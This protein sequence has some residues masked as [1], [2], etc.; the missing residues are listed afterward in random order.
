M[1]QEAALMPWLTAAR[2]VELPLRL[3]G[4]LLAMVPAGDQR[5]TSK[6]L[7]EQAHAERLLADIRKK[8]KIE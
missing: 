4:H 5:F 2:N 6:R 7:A 3:A 1:F 8:G